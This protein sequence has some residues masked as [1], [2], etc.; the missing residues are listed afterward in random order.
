MEATSPYAGGRVLEHLA[1]ALHFLFVPYI[2]NYNA[3][4]NFC[5]TYFPIFLQ[6]KKPRFLPTRIHHRQE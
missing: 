3:S 6:E 2:T 1:P 5:K 4:T